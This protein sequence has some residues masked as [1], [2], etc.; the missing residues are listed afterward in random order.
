AGGGHRRLFCVGCATRAAPDGR[1][2]NS[3]P[4]Q[5]PAGSRRKVG[6]LL[7]GLVALAAEA[8]AGGVLGLVDVLG[9][10]AA[11]ALVDGVAALVDALVHLVRVVV[12]ELLGLVEDSHVSLPFLV[13]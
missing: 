8:L 1:N 11:G 7:L 5:W 12:R 2:E 13:G 4:A 10:L 9:V 6:G 3:P